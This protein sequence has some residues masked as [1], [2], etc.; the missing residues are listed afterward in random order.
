MTEQIH[1]VSKTHKVG[2]KTSLS[3]CFFFC[4]GLHSAYRLPVPFSPPVPG[5]ALGDPAALAGCRS[6][7]LGAAALQRAPSVSDLAEHL[8]SLDAV[9]ARCRALETGQERGL[10]AFIQH[11]P[12]RLM[13]N[14]VA[15]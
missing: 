9:A 1:L 10:E 11:L 14:V 5:G 7:A 13:F 6:G 15:A 4:A 12:P 2:G 3:R 8:P